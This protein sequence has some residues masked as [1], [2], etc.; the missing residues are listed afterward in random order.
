MRSYLTAVLWLLAIGWKEVQ[1]QLLNF[2]GAQPPPSTDTVE[3][4]DT[5]ILEEFVLEGNATVTNLQESMGAIGCWQRIV[6]RPLGRP[7]YACRGNKVKNMGFCYPPCTENATG[8]G[9]I[10][11]DVKKLKVMG[12]GKP[13]RPGCSTNETQEGGLCYE[14]CP[15]GYLGGGPFCTEEGPTYKPVLES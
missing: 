11:L 4:K 1:A 6:R 3:T 2:P 5:E 12:R 7:V 13:E 14:Q 15:E 8:I 10:C 9:P